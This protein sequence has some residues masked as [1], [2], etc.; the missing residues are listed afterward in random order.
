[1]PEWLRFTQDYYLVL[2][3]LAVMVLMLF[4]PQGIA[5]LGELLRRKLSV[6]R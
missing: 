3:A 2:F 4:F 1:L 5:G 6:K